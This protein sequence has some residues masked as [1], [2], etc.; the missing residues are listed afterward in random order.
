MKMTVQ[1][2]FVHR[3]LRCMPAVE[4]YLVVEQAAL[5]HAT[6]KCHLL[7]ACSH[8][9]L[10]AQGVQDPVVGGLECSDNKG[11]CVKCILHQDQG[12]QVLTSSYLNVRLYHYSLSHAK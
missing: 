9:D 2:V 3:E 1:A 11:E 6:S 12:A 4:P 7:A 10:G 8:E 5:A